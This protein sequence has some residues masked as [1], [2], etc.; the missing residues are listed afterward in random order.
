MFDRFAD[1]ARKVMGLARQQA[2]RFNHDYIGVEP[3]M[4]SR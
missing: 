4:T 3:R 1:R 2:Q